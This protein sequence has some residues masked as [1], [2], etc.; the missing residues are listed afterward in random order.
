MAKR[1]PES[2]EPFISTWKVIAD[3]LNMSVST[4]KRKHKTSLKT[5]DPMPL[6]ING[7]I[8]AI[9]SDLRDWMRRQNKK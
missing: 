9:P 8:K 7:M 2:V 5:E 3:F 4:L 1:L 6:I